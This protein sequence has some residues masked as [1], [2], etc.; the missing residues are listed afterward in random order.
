VWFSS[1]QSSDWYFRIRFARNRIQH[2]QGPHTLADHHLATTIPAV[3]L[4][5]RFRNIKT[6]CANLARGRL[7]SMWFALAQPP[8]GT[9][10]PHG[11]RLPQHQK[12]K[13][14]QAG[15]MSAIPPKSTLIERDVC[16]VSEIRAAHSIAS[17]ARPSNAGGIVM[18][19]AFAVLRLMN[20]S[21]FV[22][23]WTGRSAGFSPLRMR[24]V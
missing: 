14:P 10:M 1:P 2:P 17:S 19:R 22:D 4:E 23:C 7:P 5:H 15:D 16:F 11:G 13:S 9:S 18:P 21:T 3:D 12:R 20:R 6:D 8:Y 24:P